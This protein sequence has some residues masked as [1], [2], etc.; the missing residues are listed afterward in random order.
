MPPDI[1]C[2]TGCGLRAQA[3]TQ[4][5]TWLSTAKHAPL[6]LPSLQ[7]LLLLLLLLLLLQA[8]TSRAVV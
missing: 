1:K 6:A 8:L 2:I 4:P 5:I 3:A 7:H